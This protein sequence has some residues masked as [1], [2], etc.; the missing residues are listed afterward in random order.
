[1]SMAYHPTIE[2]NLFSIQ[3]FFEDWHSERVWLSGR[4]NARRKQELSANMVILILGFWFSWSEF[5]L[6]LVYVNFLAVA[7]VAV[8]SQSQIQYIDFLCFGLFLSWG[9]TL[10]MSR[11]KVWCQF[12]ETDKEDGGQ[13]A[14]QVLLWVLWKGMPHTQSARLLFYCISGLG[15]LWAI[16]S[17][18]VIL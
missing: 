9:N 1:M 10:V 4:R 12:E 16:K 14:L 5:V 2:F 6:A 18:Q 7:W 15:L 13:S 3:L 17:H 11:H 8:Q